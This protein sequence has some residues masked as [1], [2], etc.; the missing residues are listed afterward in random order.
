MLLFNPINK[1]IIDFWSFHFNPVLDKQRIPP[2]RRLNEVIWLE[3]ASSQVISSK[4]GQGIISEAIAHF[5]DQV[6]IW[7]RPI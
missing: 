3:T 4:Q 6:H 1:S 5:L 2:S 7:W